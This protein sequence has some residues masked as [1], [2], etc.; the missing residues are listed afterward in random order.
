MRPLRYLV[1]TCPSQQMLQ[2]FHERDLLIRFVGQ[3]N[4]HSG[5]ESQ[6]RAQSM[7]PSPC[8]NRQHEGH[9]ED[10]Q[11]LAYHHGKAMQIS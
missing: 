9:A 4:T 6:Q 8:R 7:W 5:L 10:I 11:V 2:Q 1:V 3:S